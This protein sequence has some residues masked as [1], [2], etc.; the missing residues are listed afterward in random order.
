MTD[1]GQL[2]FVVPPALV[3][4]A[5]A[6]IVP[7]VPRRVG[8]VLMVLAPLAA[9]LAVVSLAGGVTVPASYFG[10]DLV[11]VRADSLTLPFGVIFAGMAAVAGLYGMKTMTVPE[12]S[13][14]LAYAGGALG[15]VYAG[16]LLTLFIFWEVKAV[17]SAFLIWARRTPTS[18]AAGLRY[19]IVHLAGGT[20]LLAGIIWRLADTGSLAFTAFE[21]SGPTALILAGILLA[22]AVPPLHAWLADAYPEASV[23]GTVFLSAFTTKAAVYTLARGFPGVD[24]LVWLGVAMALYGVVYAVLE[25]DIRRLLGYHIVSQV[26]YMVAAVGIGTAAA[27]NGAVAHAFAHILY[28]GLLL[29]G[30]GAVLYATGRSKLTELGGLWRAMPFVVVLYMIGAFSISGVPLFSG[31]VSKELAVDA[32]YVDGRVAVFYLLKLASVGT[33]LHTG[34]KLPYFTWAGPDRDLR[35]GPVPPTMIAAMAIAAVANITIGLAPGLLYALLPFPVEFAPYAAG[36]VVLLLQLLTFTALGFWLL[37]SKLGGEATVTLDTDWIYRKL[38]RTLAGLPSRRRAPAGR[39]VA[40]PVPAGARATVAGLV[41]YRPWAYTPR[42]LSSTGLLG[43]V[44]LLVFVVLLAVS[45]QP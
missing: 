43:V 14:A 29:M 8:S 2:G 22:A 30:A 36:R 32:A 11:L 18:G 40:E 16:D 20:T 34:L 31:F 33:F 12:R 45:L 1:L 21:L 42:S 15:V 7:L 13:A 38:P 10:F 9:L 27:L 3:L 19:L 17:A 39:E 25:N 6:A 28:K 44:V 4:L 26:G 41:R 5:A 24:L 35:A 37:L 23:A